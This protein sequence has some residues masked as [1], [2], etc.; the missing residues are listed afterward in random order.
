MTTALQ[1]LNQST[2]LT[3]L[4]AAILEAASEEQDAYD[5]IPTRVKISPGGS[6]I[7]VTEDGESFRDFTAIVAVSQKARAY[8]PE[9]GTG[10]P[11]MCSSPDGRR[12]YI[13][14]DFDDK[15]GQAALQAHWPHP[16]LPLLDAEAELPDHFDCGKCPL[17]K[18][19]SAHQNGQSRGQACKALRRLVVLVD[20]W[21]QPAMITLPPTSI[22]PWDT[23]ASA[24]ARSKS[25]YFAVRTKFSLSAAEAAGGEPYSVAS[26]QI[27][28]ALEQEA[29]SLVLQVRQEYA[30]F[31]RAME[32][33]PDEYETVPPSDGGDDSDEDI[34]F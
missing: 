12:G 7:Y 15:Q 31:V 10:K 30:E 33:A 14:A 27:A 29:L 8:W 2:E 6:N 1:K 24:L 28:E 26:F 3:E 5:L 18:F 9:R 21:A 22:K 11:P 32:I 23:Y 20:G 13:R 16:V 34:P 25:A 4:E 17:S 19:G